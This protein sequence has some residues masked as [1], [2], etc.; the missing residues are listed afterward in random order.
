MDSIGNRNCNFR[1]GLYVGLNWNVQTST[2]N[3]SDSVSLDIPD[4][5]SLEDAE[6]LV[7][8]ALCV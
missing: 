5:L 3:T 4:G 2:G 8:D 6:V 7:A 1:Q